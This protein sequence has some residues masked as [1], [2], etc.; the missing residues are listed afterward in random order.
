MFLKMYYFVRAIVIN[1]FYLPV[2]E[3]FIL[4]NKYLFIYCKKP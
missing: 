1:I 3:L 2:T 4:I